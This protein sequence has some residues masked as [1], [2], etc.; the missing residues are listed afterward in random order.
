MRALSPGSSSAMGISGTGLT[1]LSSSELVGTVL[2]LVRRRRSGGRPGVL[3]TTV[4]VVVSMEVS[5]LPT[6]PSMV[7]NW[8]RELFRNMV[9]VV[10]VV[11][12]RLLCKI[13]STDKPMQIRIMVTAGST[14]TNEESG[15][16]R[17]R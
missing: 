4:A 12:W 9:V 13:Y 14:K 3:L 6:E 15:T 7:D 2:L 16:R 10:V 8:P 5:E 17:R 11:E 1:G